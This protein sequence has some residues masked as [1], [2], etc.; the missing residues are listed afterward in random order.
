MR[1]SWWWWFHRLLLHSI[2]ICRLYLYLNSI[3]MWTEIVNE[4]AFLL[5]NSLQYFSVWML[6]ITSITENNSKYNY[7]ALRKEKE[8]KLVISKNWVIRLKWHCSNFFCFE[9]NWNQGWQVDYITTN[10]ESFVNYVSISNTAV[11][12]IFRSMGTFTHECSRVFTSFNVFWV[13]ILFTKHIYRCDEKQFKLV[14][15]SWLM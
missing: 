12:E 4:L 9:L 6:L 7:G 8:S 14:W 13:Y 5:Q 10:V 3:W 15:S 1:W 2:L 11:T